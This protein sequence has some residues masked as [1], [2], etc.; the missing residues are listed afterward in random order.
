MNSALP[1][2]AQLENELDFQN[3]DTEIKKTAQSGQF[4]QRQSNL[5]ECPPDGG[6]DDLPSETPPRSWMSSALEQVLERK[7]RDFQPH[8]L[9]GFARPLQ[10]ETDILPSRIEKCD[11]LA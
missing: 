1:R 3:Q 6:V 4:S 2:R 5:I 10:R 8:L 11:R 9:I 7:L